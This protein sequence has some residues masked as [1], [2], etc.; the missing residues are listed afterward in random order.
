MFLQFLDTDDV[1]TFG[2]ILLNFV[3]TYRIKYET[4]MEVFYDVTF[5]LVS[6]NYLSHPHSTL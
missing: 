6:D 2:D 3:F 4:T 1:I 5:H